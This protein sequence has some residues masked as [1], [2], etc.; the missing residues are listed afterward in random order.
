M[1]RILIDARVRHS[2]RK[3][4]ETGILLLAFVF[5][6]AFGAAQE[7]QPSTQPATVNV[8][9]LIREMAK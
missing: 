1:Q 9:Q 5:A 6:A 3:G 8:A 2:V 7:S 4:S